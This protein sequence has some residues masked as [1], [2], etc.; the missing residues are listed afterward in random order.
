MVEPEPIPTTPDSRLTPPTTYQSEPTHF[1]EKY[2]E[3]VPSRK[4]GASTV[5]ALGTVLIMWATTGTWDQEETIASITLGVTAV[6]AYLLKNRSGD[7]N[8][9][10]SPV[11]FELRVI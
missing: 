11:T 2:G 5:G 4:W 7:P 6:T 8:E 1:R 9:Q 10:D 3:Y